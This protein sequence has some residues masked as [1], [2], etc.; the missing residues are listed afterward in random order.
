M[1]DIDVAIILSRCCN[2]GFG[3]CN[4]PPIDIDEYC[5]KHGANVAVRIFSWIQ[6]QRRI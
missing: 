2:Y 3:C 5:K 6:V 4:I 1:V